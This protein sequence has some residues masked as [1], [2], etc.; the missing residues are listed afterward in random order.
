MTGRKRTEDKNRCGTKADAKAFAKESRQILLDTI[1]PA[2]ALGWRLRVWFWM[3][4]RFG[5]LTRQIYLAC[6]E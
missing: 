5:L 2:T 3:L 1:F 6:E 4:S